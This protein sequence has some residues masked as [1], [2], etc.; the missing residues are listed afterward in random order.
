MLFID[1]LYYNLSRIDLKIKQ[2][3]RGQGAENALD[4]SGDFLF[5]DFRQKLLLTDAD[6]NVAGSLGQIL[7]AMHCRRLVLSTALSPRRQ[8]WTFL[9]LSGLRYQANCPLEEPQKNVEN[10]KSLPVT[11]TQQSSWDDTWPRSPASN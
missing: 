4:I 3:C 8:S 10:A 9:I 2:T 6:L 5:N 7:P 11:R 1:T